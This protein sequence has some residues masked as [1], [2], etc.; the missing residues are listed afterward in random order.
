MTR[1]LILLACLLCSPALGD[2]APG[3]IITLTAWQQIPDGDK[4][5]R[6]WERIIV[7]NPLFAGRTFYITGDWSKAPPGVRVR[8]MQCVGKSYI[9]QEGWTTNNGQILTRNGGLIKMARVNGRI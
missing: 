5:G 1:T 7:I 2:T 3:T 6:T 8:W 9:A 4:V